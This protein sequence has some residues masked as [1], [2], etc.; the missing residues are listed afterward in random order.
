MDRLAGKVALITGGGNGQGAAEARLFASEG[1]KV[2]IG[3]IA[4]AEGQ[5]VAA[6]IGD[7]AI[8]VRHDVRSEHDWAQIVESG[9]EAFG[10]IDVLVNNAGL[11][12][13]RSIE[14]TTL[15][16]FQRS[17]DVNQTGAFLGMK[18]VFPSMQS[19]GCGS[20]I[21]VSSIDGILGMNGVVAYASA[22]FA[23]R[24]MSRVAALEWGRFGIRVNTLHPGGVDTVMWGDAPE[25]SKIAPFAQQPI[26]RIGKPI[27]LAKV[28]LFLASDDSS[29]CTGAEF[30]ADGGH[31]A[32]KREALAP[33]Y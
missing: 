29:Y 9:R 15:A 32:G 20:I 8:F 19:A 3:D 6:E 7:S 13:M 2:V 28:A 14:D 18:A 1:A 10:S 17:V 22:K 4:E 27:E 21:N 30:L 12:E 31:C 16:D 25:E 33:G 26:P 5:A 24:G 23:L 11:L